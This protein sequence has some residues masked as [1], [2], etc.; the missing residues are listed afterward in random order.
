M[1]NAFC[2]KARTIHSTHERKTRGVFTDR[3]TVGACLRVSRA[4]AGG[5]ALSRFSSGGFSSYCCR[6]WCP[7]EL[8]HSVCDRFVFAFTRKAKV[9]SA[10]VGAACCAVSFRMCVSH[11]GV[12]CCVYVSFGVP[13]IFRAKK[14]RLAKCFSALYLYLPFS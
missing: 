8:G 2:A 4:F 1:G 5:I 3:L 11:F 12:S 9:S 6:K 10:V 7:F 13:V 14:S